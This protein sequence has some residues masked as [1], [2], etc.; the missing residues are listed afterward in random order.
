MRLGFGCVNLGSAGG[1]HSSRAHVRLVHEALDRGV[2]VFD[3]AD[4][5]G[6]GASERILGRALHDRRDGIVV[7]TK[8]GYLF[9][10]RSGVEQSARRLAAR[11]L[12]AARRRRADPAGPPPIG[13]GGPAYQERDD[14]P[15]H[16]RG[17]IESSLRRLRTDHID[18]YQ[19][20]GPDAVHPGLFDELQDLVDAGKVGAFGIGAE[21]VAAAVAWLDVPAVATIQVPFGVLDPQAATELLPRLDA[22]AVDVW[23]RGVLGGGL[24]RLVAR[25][26]RAAAADPKGPVLAE[27]GA[28]AAR[29]EIDLDA[30]ALGYV[31]SFS[32]V[33]TLLVGIS[34]S[35]HLERNVALMEA[36][37]LPDHVHAELARVTATATPH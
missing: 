33:S 28:L 11:T 10:E 31:R 29:A 13:Q 35:A 15:R 17:A 18:V 36:P 16:L 3:T 32:A 4:A 23:A 8:G 21:S 2:R 19:L 5:Y 34:S 37:A 12:R 20:H 7:A 25:D 1:A 14:S 27:L 9:R 24:L 30:L 6:N 22:R 26:P